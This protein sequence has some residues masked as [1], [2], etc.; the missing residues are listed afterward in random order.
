M[1]TRT[2]FICP[3]GSLG[4][5]QPLDLVAKWKCLSY[6]SHVSF[7]YIC[8]KMDNNQ[9]VGY[10]D[11]KKKKKKNGKSHMLVCFRLHVLSEQNV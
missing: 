5:V 6:P 7:M 1:D 3:I 9:I 8:P 10:L 2:G 11:N 4:S